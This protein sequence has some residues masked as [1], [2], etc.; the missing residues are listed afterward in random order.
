MEEKWMLV[1]FPLAAFIVAWVLASWRAQRNQQ[2]MLTE[3]EVTRSTLEQAKAELATQETKL[4]Q[5]LEQKA[6]LDIAYGRMETDRDNNKDQLA[7]LDAEIIDHKTELKRARQSEQVARESNSKAQETAAKLQEQITSNA[8]TFTERLAERDQQRAKLETQLSTL[9]TQIKQTA[10]QLGETRELHAQAQTQLLEKQNELSTYKGWWETTKADLKIAQ[11][12]YA[13]LENA[14]VQLNTSLQEKQLSFDAQFKQL[15]ENRE[16][17]T[18]EFERLANDV[19]E[20]KGKA[21][22]ELNQESINNLIAPLQTEMKGFRSRIEDI[23]TKDAEQRVELRTEL[24]NLQILNKDITD[25][26]EKLT[27]ALRGQKK[28]QGNWGE[29][30]LENVLDN[31]GLRLGTDYK[32]EVS[33]NTEDGRQRPDAIVYLP[34]NKH[35]IIDAKTS[36]VA[37][38]DFIN[39]QDDLIRAQALAA[40]TA[41]VSDRINELADRNYYRLAGLN[42]PEVVIMFIPIESAYV[43]A[44]RHDESLFQ[45]AI[46]RNV[47]VATPTT[48][49]T[50]LKI[51]KQLWSFEDRNKHTAE[52]ASRAQRFYQKLHGFLTSMLAVGNQLDKAK[53]TYEKALGQLYTG[54]G[55]LIKQAS[56]FKELGVSVQKELPVELLERAKLELDADVALAVAEEAAPPLIAVS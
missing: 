9:E 1:A 44:L 10:T 27:T 20:R 47:L 56:E 51:V 31:S 2:K 21:F 16:S 26:A 24:K 25:Q 46:E 28:V 13:A 15:N 35:M 34:Q 54:R 38:T 40:H 30:M 39:A 52:L 53:D 19:L 49:L 22:K 3:V 18:K 36:L 55:N 11:E 23:H 7:K 5:L 48:L 43:E 42:S 14:H 32:R 29:L 17:L 37:Y 12:N 45:R 50:S 6:A 4:A 41:A 33:F 8:A